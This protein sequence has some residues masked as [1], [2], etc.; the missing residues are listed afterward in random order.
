MDDDSDVLPRIF[1][2]KGFFNEAAWFS[3][4]AALVAE[5]VVALLCERPCKCSAPWARSV[6]VFD[7]CFV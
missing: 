5:E 4:D 2:G 6:L 3:L 7:R 1:V